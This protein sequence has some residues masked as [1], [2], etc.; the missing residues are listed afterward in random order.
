VHL[1]LTTAPSTQAVSD[2]EA[3]AHAKIDS[4]SA[5]A[6]SALI[7]DLVLS[8]IRWV[9]RYTGR[10]L[11]TQTITLELEEDEFVEPFYIPRPPFGAVTSLNMYDEDDNATEVTSAGYRIVGD[12]PARIVQ[13]GDGW[14]I[15]NPVKAAVLVYTAGYGA[16]STVPED[17]KTA[18]RMIF[19]DLYENRQ[20][21]I[22]GTIT[23]RL[24]L[25][26]ELLAHYRIGHLAEWT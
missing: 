13:K 3:V 22:V 20:T 15:E 21:V 17:I 7:T 18:I 5:T 19:T 11:V 14:T 25:V 1:Q 6:D 12:D 4:D 10:A 23:A 24:P 9:E 8:A 26:T 2:A 16:A